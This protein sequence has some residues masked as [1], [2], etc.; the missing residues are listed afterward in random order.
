MN[1]T[2]EPEKCWVHDFSTPICGAIA[3]VNST[4]ELVLLYFLGKH[5]REQVVAL[6]ESRGYQVEWNA[7]AVSA[8]ETQVAE[9]FTGI[10]RTFDLP[11]APDGTSFQQR[12]WQ[13]LLTIPFGETM[14][15]GELA[16]R[17]GN[18]KASRAVGGA[19]GQ[20]PI[21]LIIPCHRV[22]GSNL[23]LTGYGGG[24]N[25]KEALLTHEGAKFAPSRLRSTTE[26]LLQAQLGLAVGQEY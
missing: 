21:S 11:L 18:P 3:G 16:T 13:E 9:Y 14:S 24:L 7:E 22:I 19:N 1:R 23:S 20:N 15:Y 8:V 2:H 10:R 12:V 4:G 6:L 25:V 17:V 5:E 26:E